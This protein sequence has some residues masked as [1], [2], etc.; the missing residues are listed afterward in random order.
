MEKVNLL[1]VGID[2]LPLEA[3]L[4]RIRRAACSD[5]RLLVAYINITGLN[6]AYEQPWLRR[7][8]NRAGLVYA[9][10][11][12]LLL[13]ARLL[14]KRI[15][16]RYTLADWVWRLAETARQAGLSLYLLGNPPG[17]ASRAAARLQQGCPGLCIAGAQHGY[18]DQ[19]PGSAEDEAVLAA[20]NAA[21]PDILLVGLGMPAQE[22]W[23]ERHWERLQAPVVI[24]VGALFE[25]VSG[26]LRRGPAWMTQHYLEWLARALLQ[27]RR[28]AGR[29]ARDIPL[30][31]VR[32]IRQRLR[33]S[34]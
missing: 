17:V 26:D 22:R 27:P 2:P 8:Y 11:M 28:Y 16:E 10:G 6:L 1:G 29:Y 19:S 5:E 14:G 24:S 7:Y 23:L 12:G 30:F 21:G 31:L 25:Y 15:P 9:D 32:I 3:A 4:E 34:A 20:I 13:G 33:G 18:F